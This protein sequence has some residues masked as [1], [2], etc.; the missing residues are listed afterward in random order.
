[1]IQPLPSPPPPTVR[2][3]PPGTQARPTP[4]PAV[5]ATA[6]RGDVPTAPPPPPAPNADAGGGE[7]AVPAVAP[8]PDL[9]AATTAA[10]GGIALLPLA[11]WFWPAVGAV[12]ALL[13]GWL[14]FRRRKSAAPPEVTEAAE[15]EETEA[16]P[17][18]PIV[19]APR[20][21]MA[22]KR[23][24]IALEFEATSARTS[25]VGATVGYRL[26]VRNMGSGE[27]TG[28][29]IAAT[30]GNAAAAQDGR[31]QS[32][33]AAPV[34]IATHSVAEL[35]PGAET[36][37]SGELLLPQEAYSPV[38]VQ[39]RILL[40]PMVAFNACYG[41]A[42]GRIGQT[43]TSYIVGCENEPPG[44]KL[45]AFRLDRGPRQYRSVG[46]RKTE[47]ALSA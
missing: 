6:P 23:P 42:G 30:I 12:A 46:A 24:W 14:L 8:Q 21:P 19:R 47:A 4:R 33:F 37:L 34:D 39:D 3:V 45:S 16:A 38:K 36:V 9:P 29:A 1:M 32:F 43:A 7:E 20:S 2:A 41:W 25:L 11:R 22:V 17:P 27:A 31:L 5:P 10:G 40:I 35:A 13:I 15:T 18:Q 28:I 44:E 26:T